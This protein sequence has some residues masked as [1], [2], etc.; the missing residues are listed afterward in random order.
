MDCP[1]HAAWPNLVQLL[2][3]GGI[4]AL[5]RI[6]DATASGP[7]PDQPSADAA[8][9]ALHRLKEW[10]ASYQGSDQDQRELLHRLNDWL[11]IDYKSDEENVGKLVESQSVTMA[12]PPLFPDWPAQDLAGKYMP[13]GPIEPVSRHEAH[14][15]INRVRAVCALRL[16]AARLHALSPK[17][18]EIP[19]GWLRPFRESYTARVQDFLD[20]SILVSGTPFLPFALLLIGL[21]IILV[22]ITILPS[23]LAELSPP[24]SDVHSAS[25]RYGLWLEDRAGLVRAGGACLLVAVAIV[26]PAGSIAGFSYLNHAWPLWPPQQVAYLL[27][28][29]LGRP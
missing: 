20:Q 15:R 2:R 5:K 18:A 24:A 8:N 26:W 19:T 10:V 6:S 7:S 12:L 25:W 29:T 3:G 27:S 13:V 1:T 23:V 21:C 4:D 28:L 9:G 16:T 11:E 14:I 17:T 22:V